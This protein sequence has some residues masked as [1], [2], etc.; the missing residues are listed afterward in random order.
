MQKL[1][2][3]SVS[4]LGRG[5]GEIYWEQNKEIVILRYVMQ[6]IKR[7]LPVLQFI[8]VQIFIRRGLELGNN[9]I[10]RHSVR[11]APQFTW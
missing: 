1:V 2:F 3:L 7:R 8:N 4:C 9:D 10:D 11:S 6:R 5:K